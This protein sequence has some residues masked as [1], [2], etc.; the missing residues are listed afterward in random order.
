MCQSRCCTALVVSGFAWIALATAPRAAFAAGDRAVD[1]LQRAVLARAQVN[2]SGVATLT[3]SQPG[4]GTRTFTEVLYCKQGGKQSVQVKDGSD[5]L[6][7]RR[8]C[9]GSTQWESYVAQG[10][11]VRRPVPSVSERQQRDL[12]NL[13]ILTRN[14]RT[15]LVGMETVAGRKA[16]HIRI[17]RSGQPS[18]LVRQYWIDKDT[19]LELK[20][21]QYGDGGVLASSTTMTRV[22]FH[23]DYPPGVFTFAPPPNVKPKVADDAVFRG[24]LADAETRVGFSAILPRTVPAG[25]QLLTQSVAVVNRNGTPALWLRYTNGIDAFSL[26]Q[27]K[28][29]GGESQAKGRFTVRQWV[30]GGYQFLL[31]GKLSSDQI[32]AIRGSYR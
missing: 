5:Q 1:I 3:E 9:D 22:N 27:R 8:T 25:F 7:V 30:S 29:P 21:E 2:Y 4:G 23:P 17:S 32:E 10:A 24:P 14:F 11:V 16:Y 18:A 12:Q 31:V 19:Y 13:N 20:S 15:T 6:V 26:F 28:A